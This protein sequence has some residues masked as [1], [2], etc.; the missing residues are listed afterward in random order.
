MKTLSK[1]IL[2]NHKIVWKAFSIHM[3]VEPIRYHRFA[4]LLA[5]FLV[6]LTLSQVIRVLSNSRSSPMTERT[7]VNNEPIVLCHWHYFM[8]FWFLQALCKLS[9]THF[10]DFIVSSA[11]DHQVMECWWRKQIARPCWLCCKYSFVPFLQQCKCSD[12]IGRKS[13]VMD[14]LRFDDGQRW[15][16]DK[17]TVCGCKVSSFTKYT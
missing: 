11:C 13:C 4:L 2:E 10:N 1:P 16:K 15:R 9:D 12:I 17:C 3:N 7:H 6:Y 8:K 5:T 14:G